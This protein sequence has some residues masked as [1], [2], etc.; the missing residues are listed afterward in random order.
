[1]AALTTMI[2]NST[3]WIFTSSQWRFVGNEGGIHWYLAE[4][5][6]KRRFRL[7]LF[8]QGNLKGNAS[9]GT[10]WKEFPKPLVIRHISFSSSSICMSQSIF[11]RRWVFWISNKERQHQSIIQQ[12]EA[13]DLLL[14]GFLVI[15]SYITRHY[16]TL[17]SGQNHSSF[18]ARALYKSLDELHP[19]NAS[20]NSCR[21]M[22]H[23]LIALMAAPKL[24][25]L[26]WSSGISWEAGNSCSF[27]LQGLSMT[28]KPCYKRMSSMLWTGKYEWHPSVVGMAI[29]KPPNCL[30]WGSINP[31][32]DVC[33]CVCFFGVVH[34]P[35]RNT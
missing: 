14:A 1:M 5:H 4:S 27:N 24:T 15:S 7:I 26:R 6:L 13:K 25:M 9:K 28:L 12:A 35:K 34:V 23:S 3:L 20:S 2:F 11:D 16:L 30:L 17:T 18:K 8:V 19:P 33:V 10:L 29:A 32:K 22:V 31:M 21:A